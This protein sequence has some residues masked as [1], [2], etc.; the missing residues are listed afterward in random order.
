[1]SIS[2]LQG[3]KKNIHFSAKDKLLFNK[4]SNILE[5]FTAHKKTF[6]D[7]EEA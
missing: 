7:L 3:R 1:M 2:N 4:F 6:A 5:S